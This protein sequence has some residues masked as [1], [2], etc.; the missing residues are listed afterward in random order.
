M[1]T[2]TR[3]RRRARY[4]GIVARFLLRSR[5]M[6][7]LAS[8]NISAACLAAAL[9][10]AGGCGQFLGD[11]PE[12]ASCSG[13]ET[14]RICSH[15]S[16]SAEMVDVPCEAGS[17]LETSTGPI[18]SLSVTQVPP[19]VNP[20]HTLSVPP[21]D[22]VCWDNTSVHCR[23]GF[24]HEGTDCG[25]RSCTDTVACG[26]V[27]VSSSVADHAACTRSGVTSL[28]VDT[29]LVGCGC[30]REA[31]T[32]TACPVACADAAADVDP[33]EAFCALGNTIDTSCP[34]FRGGGSEKSSAYCDGS[35]RVQCYR[36]YAIER[37]PC[38]RCRVGEYGD[39]SCT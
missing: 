35:T 29:T 22:T 7:R 16:G 28:C 15:D 1:S 34:D 6:R 37:Q 11:C 31:A 33:P 21:A 30:G 5:G 36:K 27:C 38:T 9:G 23:E 25:S 10:S 13:A 20:P 17:C 3:A 4:Q 26:A 18:C 12:E 14:R 2:A 24:P 39:V 8:P 19:C 32:E